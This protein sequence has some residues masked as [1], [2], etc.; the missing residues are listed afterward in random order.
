[1]TSVRYEPGS[2]ALTVEGHAGAGPY[3]QDL[4]CAA[5][6][7]LAATLEAAVSDRAETLLPSVCRGPGRLRI[8]CRP[9]PESCGL[10]R[11][12]YETV[13]TGFELLGSRY[14]EHVQT[15]RI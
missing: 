5:L 12:I 13:F 3:G 6:S 4:V 11:S 7:I 1:M 2:F 14:P 9:V 10:C 15:R 8:S